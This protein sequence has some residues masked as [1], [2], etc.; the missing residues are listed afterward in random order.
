MA[1]PVNAV[2]ESVFCF[3]RMGEKPPFGG[4]DAELAA[5]ALRGIKGFHRQLMFSHDSACVR[6][7]RVHRAVACPVP[8]AEGGG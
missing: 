4:A 7:R 1:S 2:A 8:R 5:L 3:D 6:P